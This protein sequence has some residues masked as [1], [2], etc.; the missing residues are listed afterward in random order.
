M[1]DIYFCASSRFLITVHC[2][3]EPVPGVDDEAA[4][5]GM[6]ARVNQLFARWIAVRPDQWFCARR[7]WPRRN[8]RK[9]KHTRFLD[10]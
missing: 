8:A 5:I 7:R 9:A 10:P 1:R 6:T 4:A 2:P 3:V